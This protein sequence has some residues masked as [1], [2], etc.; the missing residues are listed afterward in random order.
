MSGRPR[1]SSIVIP[2]HNQ[3]AVTRRCLAA[4]AYAPTRIP[5]EMI[6]VDD[7]ST[8]GTADALAGEAPGVRLVRHDYARGFNQACCSGAAAARGTFLVLLNNDTEPCALWLEELLD[9]FERWAD[10]GLVGAQL[11]YPD[12]R[13]QE[14]GGIV[15]GNGEP[16]NYGR[17]GNPHDPRCRLR[18]PG[19]LCERCRPRHPPRPLE[20]AGG[21][22]PGVLPRLLRRHRSGLQGAPGRPHACATPPWPG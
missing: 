11:I 20:P 4:I 12:G 5:F 3:Y 18:P 7:G 19:G 17:G 6:V 14:A 13:L 10:T 8:D 16:W 21:L 15:W 1:G 2:V 22:Q 9:P